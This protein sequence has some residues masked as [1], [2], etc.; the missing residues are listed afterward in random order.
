MIPQLLYIFTG[1]IIF[2]YVSVYVWVQYINSQ[3]YLICNIS[4]LSGDQ[5]FVRIGDDC[6]VNPDLG[7]GLPIPT[8]GSEKW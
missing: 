4:S 1:L 2:T 6:L 7:L 3:S 8:Q 5:F